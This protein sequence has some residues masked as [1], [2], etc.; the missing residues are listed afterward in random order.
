MYA[1]RQAHHEGGQGVSKLLFFDCKGMVTI[2]AEEGL[3]VVELGEGIK[4]GADISAV[5]QG[6]TGL[7]Y[8]E[9]VGAQ[10]FVL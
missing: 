10:P 1:S 6:G 8:E 5:G 4:S 3:A 7:G 2:S 9:V